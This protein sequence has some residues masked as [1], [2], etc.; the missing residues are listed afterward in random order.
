MQN[1][2]NFKSSRVDELNQAIRELESSRIQAENTSSYRTQVKLRAELILNESSRAEPIS[3]HF[4]PYCR[5]S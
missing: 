1:N 3:A 5:V 4:Q 2:Y